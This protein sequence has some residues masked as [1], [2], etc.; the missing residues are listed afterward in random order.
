MRVLFIGKRRY[1]N[2]DALRER[3]GRIYQLPW[4]W[5]RAGASVQL[6]LIDYH[7]RVYEALIDGDLQVQST[8]IRGLRWI[9]VG[10][11]VAYSRIREHAPTHIVASGDPYIGFLAWVIAKLVGAVFVF[12]V[13]DKYDVFAGYHKPLGWDLFGFLLNH[14]DRCWF[15]SQ[16][17]LEQVGSAQRVDRVIPNG[18]DA[19]HFKPHDMLEARQRFRLAARGTFVGY[20]GSMEADRGI[21]DLVDAIRIL[22]GQGVPVELILAGRATDN[23]ELDQA[24]FRYLGNLPYQEVPWALAAVD[25]VAVPYR[26]SVFLD[27]ASSIKFGEIMACARP[28]VAS[29]SPNFLANFPAQAAQLGPYLVDTGNPAALARAIAEQLQHK[30][31]V[32]MPDGLDWSSIAMNAWADLSGIQQG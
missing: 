8:P 19:Q 31:I 17:L 16:R 2:R 30:L 5:A 22:R 18:L 25:V 13:Y 24:G 28:F 4:H 14:A 7:S 27:A 1:T 29:R 3:Y 10:M 26:R 12:D 15:A 20:F 21:N 6:W 9:A 11:S 32:E 23:F